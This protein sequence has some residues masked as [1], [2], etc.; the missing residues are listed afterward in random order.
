M[1]TKPKKKAPA[2]PGKKKAPAKPV[3]NKVAKK[4]AP[5]KPAKVVKTVEVSVAA[6]PPRYRGMCWVP[7]K[8]HEA[9]DGLVA[10]LRELSGESPD[11]TIEV[12]GSY[13]EVNVRG[14]PGEVW[15]IDEISFSKVRDNGGVS[16][17]SYMASEPSCLGL[18]RAAEEYLG[19]FF[20]EPYR[21]EGWTDDLDLKKDAEYRLRQ[22]WA[23]QPV[24]K[25]QLPINVEEA[26]CAFDWM[27]ADNDETD[28]SVDPFGHYTEDERIFL[29]K[30]QEFI[31]QH[32]DPE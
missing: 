14:T 22:V 11:T 17:A 13:A 9:V 21:P 24:E 23:L 18:M 32:N 7:E 10:L 12:F 16:G 19:N 20:V 31:K 8:R 2:K 6:E 26:K 3:K 25:G 28:E 4:A 5:K 27:T 1:K 30:L 29:R 15:V